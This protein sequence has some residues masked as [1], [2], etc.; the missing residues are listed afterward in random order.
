MAGG[1][2]IHILPCCGIVPRVRSALDVLD[3]RDPWG[4][5]RAE[6]AELPAGSI[7]S[8]PVSGPA[9]PIDGRQVR[10]LA[11][12][13]ALL[14]GEDPGE[15][16]VAADVGIL[17]GASR[18]SV[19]VYYD[20][21]RAK[22]RVHALGEALR[23]GSGPTVSRLRVIAALREGDL[24]TVMAGVSPLSRRPMQ[25]FT[26]RMENAIRLL[27]F[28]NA[29]EAVGVS[30]YIGDIIRAATMSGDVSYKKAISTLRLAAETEIVRVEVR[31]GCVLQGPSDPDVDDGGGGFPFRGLALEV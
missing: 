3:F 17:P 20:F 21:D 22:G 12:T 27:A 30:C 26:A 23:E 31:F 11:A 24:G 19:L 8:R 18:P 1:T 14:S 2:G 9:I 13:L 4:D 7:V 16:V 29:F 5:A 25:D 28:A 15:S 10:D 6:M